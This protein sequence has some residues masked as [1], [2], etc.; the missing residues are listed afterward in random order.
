[1]DII[2]QM[3][4]DK[5]NLKQLAEGA[6]AGF[7]IGGFGFLFS[8]IFE[9]PINTKQIF[10]HF[11]YIPYNADLAQD[12]IELKKLLD[13]NERPEDT[14]YFLQI[15]SI[16]NLLAGYD[17]AIDCGRA[18]SCELNYTLQHLSMLANDILAKMLK[19]HFKIAS[20]GT[21]V[22]VIVDRLQEIIKNILYNM[23]QELQ[24]RFMQ[25]DI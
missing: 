9:T 11:E 3:C 13:V 22:C 21:D 23:H 19:Q 2:K 18:L 1:M 20:I 15:C 17:L 16:M 7:I 10:E 4:A 5:G 24:V 8:Q 12:L 6:G 14:R 25:G